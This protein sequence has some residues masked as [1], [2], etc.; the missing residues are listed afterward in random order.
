MRAVPYMVGPDEELM[1]KDKFIEESGRM[2][3]WPSRNTRELML[4]NLNWNIC[5][6]FIPNF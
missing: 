5:T 4:V 1:F 2:N 3:F 6:D